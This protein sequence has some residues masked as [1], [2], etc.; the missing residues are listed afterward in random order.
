MKAMAVPV[1]TALMLAGSQGVALA[2]TNPATR[3]C[4]QGEQE[5][6]GVCQPLTRSPNRSSSGS[7]D[8]GNPGSTGSTG[9]SGSQGG[10]NSGGSGG[11]GGT[12]SSGG[13]NGS[14]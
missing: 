9:G 10:Q 5:I 1:L 2:Q 4:M 8:S 13:G 7:P 12:G 6:G 11:Q 3:S 14:R